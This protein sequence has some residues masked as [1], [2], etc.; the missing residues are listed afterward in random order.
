MEKSLLSY[1]MMVKKLLVIISLIIYT[2]PALQ[3]QELMTQ[4]NAATL[5]DSADRVLR[6]AFQQ[7]WHSS[8]IP[9]SRPY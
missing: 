3:R 8:G 5:A 2:L 9:G 1:F 4:I 7:T 6:N